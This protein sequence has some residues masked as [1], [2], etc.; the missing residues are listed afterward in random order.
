MDITGSFTDLQRPKREA[1]YPLRLATM[2][3]TR[4]L[5]VGLD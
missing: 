5:G 2:L 3:A 4:V 1:D